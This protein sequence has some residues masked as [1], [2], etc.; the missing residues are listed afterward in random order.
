MI[1]NDGPA[2]SQS[3][4]EVGLNAGVH[5]QVNSSIGFFGEFQIDGNDG[6]F[7]GIEFGAL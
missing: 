5:W 2:D 3:N 1:D 6:L 7:L 4:L